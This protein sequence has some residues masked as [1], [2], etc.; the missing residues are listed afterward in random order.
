MISMKLLKS[1]P[2]IIITI[3]IFFLLIYVVKTDRPFYLISN[4]HFN[5]VEQ[6]KDDDST[7]KVNKF[8]KEI[9]QSATK[10]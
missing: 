7:P 1:Y 6:S 5:L 3:L 10:N 9:S 2:V 8:L 4:F